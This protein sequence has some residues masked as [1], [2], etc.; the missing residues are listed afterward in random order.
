MN[1][2]VLILLIFSLLLFGCVQQSQQAVNADSDLVKETELL[3]EESN[4]IQAIGTESVSS[5][6]AV[7]SDS[8][9]GQGFKG[10][11][12]AGSVSP[13]LA[14]IQED[15]I[16]AKAEGKIIL[17]NFYANWCPI[18]R[19]QRP[20]FLK[21]FNELS[22]SE[23]IGF[24]VNYKD[25]ETDEFETALAREFGVTYQHTMIFLNKEGKEFKR[26]LSFLNKD[27]IISR[28]EEGK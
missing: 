6:K 24:Q 17:L 9:S 12:F 5:A 25:S 27:Q 11:V 2:F 10:E 28:L 23:I 1:K 26:D 16:K 20:E 14:F 3:K 18:C 22:D 13:Y 21:A 19:E 4:S 7:V 8:V 15:Y